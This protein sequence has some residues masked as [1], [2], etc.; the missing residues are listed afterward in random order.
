MS[1]LAATNRIVFVE[2]LGLRRPQ[3]AYRDLRRV[4]TRARSSAEGMR[5]DGEVAVLSPATI[6]FHG[7]RAIRAVNAGALKR[8]VGTALAR[9]GIRNPILWAYSPYAEALI[10]ALDPSLIVYHCVD[11]LAAH[12]GVHAGS[13]RDA[14]RRFASRADLVLASAPALSARLHHVSGSV[15]YAPNVADV[16]FFSSAAEEG[17]IDTA[18]AAL[19]GPR[20]IF[21]GTVV[22][23]KV[24]MHFLVELARLQ[25]SWSFAL[26]GPVGLG[27]ATTDIS[28]LR[29]M[30][31]IHLL[32]PR[33]YGRLPEVLRGADAAIIPYA[34]N[35]LTVSVFPMKVY[36]YLSAG[37]PVVSTRLP[38]LEGVRGLTVVPDARSAAR[39]LA[40][41]LAE[42]PGKTRA[43]Q[44]DAA[45]GHTWEARL[46]EIDT[47]IRAVKPGLQLSSLCDDR[48]VDVE[49]A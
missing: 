11:D 33:P 44:Q 19:P 22:A 25:P 13:F 40:R 24:D 47:A 37:L 2:S 20:I 1:R 15:L 14:E 4:V 8:Q 30:P 46:S 23:T 41:L 10:D 31:N 28:P 3:F 21:V 45:A 38:S 32:G 17:P 42:D 39:E 35:A 49:H 9:L 36:E 27:D 43:A 16:R 26:I 29:S 5:S 48:P 18:L 6:P 34:I 12:K 7:A